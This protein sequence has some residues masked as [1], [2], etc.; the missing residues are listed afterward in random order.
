L[1]LDNCD[2]GQVGVVALGEH[3]SHGAVECRDADFVFLPRLPYKA[4]MS[5]EPG[6]GAVSELMMLNKA[7]NGSYV[8][9]A[10]IGSHVTK[11]PV[12]VTMG[13]FTVASA[14]FSSKQHPATLIQGLLRSTVVRH[15][16]TKCFP[17]Q[18]GC[19]GPT[20]DA[21]FQLREDV[22]FSTSVSSTQIT[23][24]VNAP[25]GSGV[26]AAST[27][28]ACTGS[29]CHVNVPLP[30]KAFLAKL[31]VG[32]HTLTVS[33]KLSEEGPVVALAGSVKWVPAPATI[34]SSVVD[35]VYT[36]IP[37]RDLYPGDEFVIVVRSRFKVYFKTAQLRVSVGSGLQI[38]NAVAPT[39]TFLKAP[40]DMNSEQ[41]VVTL[42][43]RKD[44]KPSS[45]QPTMTD[46]LLL[47][48]T[49]KVDGN[50]AAGK[51][52]TITIDKL[53]DLADQNENGLA[54]SATGVIETRD[55][56]V[57]DAVR[58]LPSPFQ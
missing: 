44:G 30:T 8:T 10:L 53:S 25:I 16:Q 51:K 58:A 31:P 12:K 18:S 43:G 57:T 21:T 38:V 9:R 29:I 6:F 40:I 46:E 54:P 5:A 23:V 41:A 37:S 47:T 42:A 14:A 36:V 28:A 26:N 17:A 20:V 33:Y 39:N 52:A 1:V 35:T 13:G 56:V 34:V 24:F 15:D 7:D 32:E 50:V 48:L 45:A 55:G 19:T 2:A 11:T 4:T 27:Q 22:T 49:L 3:E